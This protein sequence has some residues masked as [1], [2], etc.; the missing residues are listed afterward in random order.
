MDRVFIVEEFFQ[1]RLESNSKIL[2]AYHTFK[3]A[4]I[5]LSNWSEHLAHPILQSFVTQPRKNRIKTLQIFE[6]SS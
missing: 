3:N 2:G 6:F 1:D 4:W 5:A